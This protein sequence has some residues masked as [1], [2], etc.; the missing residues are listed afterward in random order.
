MRCTSLALATLATF[1]GVCCAW[2]LFAAAR[3]ISATG[4]VWLPK[5]SRYAQPS[6]FVPWQ[7]AQ[8]YIL[9]LVAF[10][11]GGALALPAAYFANG[12][13]RASVSLFLGGAFLALFQRFPLPV[14]IGVALFALSVGKMVLYPRK[15]RFSLAAGVLAISLLA[16]VFFT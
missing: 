3:D 12:Y 15:R 2:V 5:L 14:T 1:I 13:R 6:D 11:A 7:Q 10:A 8:T 16:Y 4:T 9:T